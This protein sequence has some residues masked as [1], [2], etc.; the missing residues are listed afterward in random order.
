VLD[1]TTA[2]ADLRRVPYLIGTVLERSKRFQVVDPIAVGDMF[3]AGGLRVEE[4]LARPERAVRAAKNLDVAGWVVPVL[5]ERRGAVTLDVTYISAI[6][7][8]ALF[9]RRLNLLPNSAVE[10][11]RFPW[12]PPVED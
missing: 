6:T 7:G 1:M 10:E 5:L 12:E 4:M 2:A 11:Q 3:A 8:V 9:S